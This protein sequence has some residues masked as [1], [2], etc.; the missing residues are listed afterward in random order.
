MRPSVPWVSTGAQSPI[1]AQRRVELRHGGSNGTSG[2]SSATRAI[3][4]MAD[5]DLVRVQW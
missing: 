3:P 2:P 1:A 4:S 5:E